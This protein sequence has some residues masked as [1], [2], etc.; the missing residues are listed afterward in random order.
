MNL[1]L[2]FDNELR[3][4]SRLWLST[5]RVDSYT[6]VR[7]LVWEVHISEDQLLSEA[8]AVHTASTFNQRLIH[9]PPRH[10]RRRADS[11]QYN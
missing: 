10:T 6:L 2:T 11:K 1:Q 9:P 3:L 5:L 7:A 8:V 4:V